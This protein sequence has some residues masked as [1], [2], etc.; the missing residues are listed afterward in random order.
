MQHLSPFTVALSVNLEPIY[1]I[2]LAFIIFNE[3]QELGPTFYVGGSLIFLSVFAKPV[4]NFVS[5]RKKISA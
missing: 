5:K 2:A 3:H 1:A 4:I